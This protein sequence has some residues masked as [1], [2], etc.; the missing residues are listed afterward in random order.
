MNNLTKSFA[1]VLILIFVVSSLIGFF[2]IQVGLAQSATNV[3]GIISANTTWTQANSPYSLTGNIIVNN[4]V[5]LTINSGVTVNLNGYYI[6]VNGTLN[7]SGNNSYPILINQGQISF[8]PFSAAWNETAGT[9]CLV[10]NAILNSSSTPLYLSN[11]VKISN[12]TVTAS[13]GVAITVSHETSAFGPIIDNNRISGG[14]SVSQDSS[15]TISNNAFFGGGVVV[16]LESPINGGGNTSI[17]KNTICNCQIG[18][19]ANIDKS[20]VN[21]VLIDSNLIVNNTEGI[22]IYQMGGPISLPTILNNT[23]TGNA[24]GINVEATSNS[25][26]VSNNNI[27]SNTNYNLRNQ[28]NNFNATFNWWGA[29]DVPAINQTIYDYKN[30][31]NYGTV[32]FVP[33]LNSSNPQAPTFI[34]ATSDT[35]G[36]ISPSGIIRVNYGSNQTF[37]IAANNGYHILDVSVN[38]TSIGAVSSYTVQKIQGTTTISATFAPNPTPTPSPSPIPTPSTHPTPSSTPS[39]TP[40]STPSLTS[41]PTPTASPTPRSSPAPSPTPTSTPTP[42]PTLP[43]PSL[44]VS[45]QTSASYSNFKVEITGALTANGT[46]IS[47]APVLL[48]YSVNEGTSWIE[49]ATASTDNSGNFAAVWF[50]SASGTYLLNAQWTGNSTFSNAKTT[51]NFAILPYQEKSIFSVS[52]NSTVSA[53]AFNSTS[54]ELSFS[55]SGPSNTTGY[56]DIYVPKSLISDVSNLKI[57]L[58]GNPL[59]YSTDS[60]GDSWLL[61]F[62]YHHS[63]HQVTINL[64][65][66]T[67]PSFIQSQLG[68]ITIVGVVIVTSIIA[69]ALL[70]RKHKKSKPD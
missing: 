43:T 58:D 13:N 62:T 27:Y 59:P 10:T 45:C 68:E 29:T 52:S 26:T 49:L 25:Q 39:P 22:R 17:T 4:N 65:S 19:L 15:A 55:V 57:F 6:M 48:S 14:I 28:G 11:S 7:A 1:L 66:A 31:F 20:S 64:G 24:I 47:N 21:T 36:S 5:Q 67:T 40:S 12:C 46:G 60:Q 51:I 34:I 53:F 9:G 44:T 38:G 50:P 70:I 61:S 3:N 69:V 2:T 30:N 33:F 54:Q 35:Y 18:I 63:I 42:P 56:V 32:S 16:T 37:N 23:I 8:T 41:P